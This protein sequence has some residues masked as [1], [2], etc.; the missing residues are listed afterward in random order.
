MSEEKYYLTLDD[1][2]RRVI[3][4][5]LNDQ[6]TDRIQ[7]NQDTDDIDELIIKAVDVPKKKAKGI[8]HVWR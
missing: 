3:I 1:Y 5:A 7:A 2:E 4:N 8:L 6:R